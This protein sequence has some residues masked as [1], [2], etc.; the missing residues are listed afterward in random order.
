[1]KDC[2]KY[3][4]DSYRTV[5]YIGFMIGTVYQYALLKIMLNVV[6]KD[7]EV[8]DYSFN[9][10]LFFITLLIF[11]VV[12]ELLIRYYSKKLDKIPIKEIMLDSI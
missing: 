5:S 7:I 10:K 12:Y 11:T 1:M 3:I 4:L 9:F 6:F 8:P 2:R